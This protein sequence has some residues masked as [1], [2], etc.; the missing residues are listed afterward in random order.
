M[1]TAAAPLAVIER[2]EMSDGFVIGL[3]VCGIVFFGLCVYVVGTLAWLGRRL[4]DERDELRALRDDFLKHS[5][6]AHAAFRVLG[7]QKTPKKD[8]E[9]VKKDAASP[10]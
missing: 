10:E 2:N 4:A 1:K 7:L 6:D 5:W 9:W 3:G 8:S